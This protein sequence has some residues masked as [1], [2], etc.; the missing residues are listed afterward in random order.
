MHCYIHCLYTVF[1]DDK[2]FLLKSLKA[3]DA[4]P[5]QKG[6]GCRKRICNYKYMDGSDSDS[7]NVVS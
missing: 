6:K 2:E 5:I 4:S 1:T 7:E 3:E